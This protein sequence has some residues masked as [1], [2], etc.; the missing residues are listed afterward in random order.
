MRRI[1]VLVA[2]AV[3]LAA[4]GSTRDPAATVNGTEISEDMTLRWA[5]GL[6]EVRNVGSPLPTSLTRETLSLLIQRSVILAEFEAR[7]L[8]ISDADIE[9]ARLEIR[10]AFVGDEETFP[11]P[12]GR[13]LLDTLA[14][15]AALRADLIGLNDISE[16]QVEAWLA[17]HPDRFVSACSRHILVESESEA[18][19]VIDRINGGEAFED[20]AV[21][22]S[23]GPSGPAGG[24]LGCAAPAQFVPEFAEAV[25]TLEPGV[26]SAPVETQFG[27]HVIRV[28]SRS[29]GDLAEIG[30][31]VHADLRGEANSSQAQLL[32]DLL[33]SAEITVNPKFGVWSSASFS[34]Q[35]TP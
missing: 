35:P 18:L 15:S 3:L 6:A 33:A 23:V 7:G 21:E 10:Q 12:V 2:V 25:S 13:E 1:V 24:D 16:G 8:T 32:Q 4:C 5:E 30:P 31:Q 19:A 29:T 9:V 17:Q 11:E 26:V 28:D 14:A 34:V 27:F 22:V 20:V